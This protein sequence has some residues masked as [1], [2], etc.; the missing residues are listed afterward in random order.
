MT[1]TSRRGGYGE[2]ASVALLKLLCSTAHEVDD[3][4]L[5]AKIVAVFH[6]LR[7]RS[8]RFS[9][10][11]LAERCRSGARALTRVN[12]AL[13]HDVLKEDSHVDDHKE[14]EH[15]KDMKEFEDKV[16]FIRWLSSG[17]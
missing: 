1:T 10:C 13:F 17:G 9:F 15:E 12:Y 6:T 14:Q 5:Q 2:L 3:E 4:V 7:A 11:R 8:F 16:S